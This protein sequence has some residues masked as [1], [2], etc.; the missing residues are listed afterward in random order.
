MHSVLLLSPGLPDP[1]RLSEILKTRY[2]VSLKSRLN[3]EAFQGK[4]DAAIIGLDRESMVFHDTMSLV[5]ELALRTALVGVTANP[6][7][8]ALLALL[9]KGL[10]GIL[11]YPYEPER[12][13]RSME[14]VFLRTIQTPPD[15]LELRTPIEGWVELTAPSHADYLHR[16][17]QFFQAIHGTLLGEATERQI[18]MAVYELGENAIEWGNRNDPNR[19]VK[20]TYGVFEDKLVFKIEDEGEG[21]DWHERSDPTRDPIATVRQ[22]KVEGKRPGGFGLAMVRKI[23]DKVYHNEKGNVVVFEKHFLPPGSEKPPRAQ[24]EGGATGACR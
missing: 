10:A 12:T 3:A 8:D 14:A 7:P 6:N 22:R 2:A 19:R 18:L 21:F 24:S 17:Q 11:C 15:R 5:H 23:M 13:L 4:P 16:F 9:A 1:G 20:I